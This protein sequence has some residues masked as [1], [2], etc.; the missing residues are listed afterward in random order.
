MTLL[1]RTDLEKGV[2]LNNFERRGWTR[3]SGSAENSNEW[4]VYWASVN[5]VKNIFNPEYNIRLHDGQLLNHF[6]NHYELTRKDLMYKN[7]KRYMKEN[8]RDDL[9]LPID[10]FVPI[11]YNLPLE[12]TLFVEEYRKHPQQI[13]I[14]KPISSSQGKGIF[15]ISKIQQIKKWNQQNTS[16]ESY[17]VSK[18][19]EHPH[20]IG[21]KKYDLRIYVLVTSFR[22]LRVY[23]YCHGFAR[24]C[25]VRYTT[26]E[27]DNDFIH[28]TNVAIQKHNAEYNS[29]H[30]SKW[31]IH[32]LRLYLEGIYGITKSDKLFN[33]IDSIILHSLKA[34]QHVMMNDKHCFEC[35]GY[36][37]L[38]DSDLKVPPCLVAAE[39]ELR[40]S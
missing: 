22:P 19:L 29:V 28:L 3:C 38:I 9:S 8:I 18:Y 23:Q 32:N 14:L 36:D 37:I 5:T 2:L 21:G 16:K 40:C 12:Y 10:E 34:V 15:I 33:E 35:Y 4:N 31:H 6:P 27:L 39:L 26:S 17:I 13:W 11:T 20:L 7:I 25:N 30:G 1:W 24:F